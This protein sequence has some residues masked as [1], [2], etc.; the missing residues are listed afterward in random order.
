MGEILQILLLLAYLAIGLTSITVPTYAISVSY[1]AR[2]TL[3]TLEDMRKRRKDLSEKL[4]ELRKKLEKEPG[5]EGI[6][7]EINKFEE[8]EA[9]LKDRL[10]CLSVKGAV[11]YPLGGFL[12]GLICAACGIYILPGNASLLMLAS[13][14]F[15]VFGL[16]RL[17]K[18]L[19]AVEQAALRPEEK[20]LP[21]FRFSFTSGSSVETF[22]AKEQKEIEFLIINYGK[23][24]AEDIDLMIFF[25]PE[26]KLLKKPA[27]D[28]V[29][30]IPTARYPN[31]NA[32][33]FEIK[34]LHVEISQP[35]AVLVEMPEKTGS[36]KIP[37]CIRARK[38]GKSDHQLTIKVI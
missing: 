38:I 1:L 18:S 13:I 31:Y 12:L 14:I 21:T 6:K 2:E 8:E 28:I 16:Y 30:Q 15:I 32:A 4:D 33:E 24:I 3:E 10:E 5:V 27:Y 35:G 23:D 37:I 26:F 25:P 36:Y 7:E 9:E 17:A 34:I 11:G 20:L 29:K 22:K 19:L